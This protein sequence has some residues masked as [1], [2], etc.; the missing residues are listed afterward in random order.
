MRQTAVALRASFCLA[1]AFLCTAARPQPAGQSPASATRLS[2]SNRLL[3]N[4]AAVSGLHTIEVLLLVG[5][6]PSSGSVAHAAARVAALGGRVARTEPAIGYL[7]VEVPL[8]N[9]VTLVR[10]PGIQAF[11]I[12]S[13]SRGS[14]YR[15][16]PPMRNAELMRSFEVTALDVREP[17]TTDPHLPLLP[18][19]LSRQRGFTGDDVGVGRWLDE[20]PTFDGR[21]VTI[22]L[23]ENALPSFTDPT[24]RA[25]KTL[26]GRDVPKIA[27]ILNTADDTVADETRV[28]LDTSVRA[29]KAWTRVGSRTYVFPRPGAYRF[30]V[31]EVPAGTNL[32]HRFA[33]IE[34][35]KTNEVWMDTNGDASFHDEA[36]LADVNQRFEPRFLT[37]RHPSS[38]RVAFVTARGRRPHV[39][40]IYLS[41][42]SHQ[43][44]TLSVAAG[45]WTDESLASGVAPG[46]RV[47]LV[48]ISSPEPALARMFEGFM[49]AAQRPDVDVISA[50]QGTMLVP[51]TDADFSGVFFQRLEQVYRKPIFNSAGNRGPLVTSADASML[52]VGGVLS[53]ETWAALYGGRPLESL[54]VHPLSAAGPA[55]D[56]AIKPD[57]LAPVERISADLP[58]NSPLDVVPRN[59]PAHRLP[60]GYQIS[61]CTSASSPYAAGVAALLISAARQ[62]A[63]SYRGDRLA[64]ALRFSARLIPGGPA[65]WQGH[66]L[67]DIAAAWRALTHPIDRPHITASTRVVHPLAQYAARGEEGVGIVEFDGWTPGMSAIR[68]IV[69]TRHSGPEEPVTYPLAWAASDG[70]FSTPPSVTLP[71]RHAVQVPVRIE[72]RSEG[73]HSGLLELRDAATGAPLFRTQATVVA[74]PRVH[75]GTGTLRRTGTLTHMSHRSHYVHVQPGSTAIAFELEV[76]RGVVNPSIVPSHGLFPSYYMHAYPMNVFYVGKGKYVV[77]V[78]NPQPGTWTF[79]LKATSTTGNLLPTNPVRPDDSD[80]DYALTVRIYDAAS[81]LTEPGL[82]IAPGYLTTHTGQFLAS[83]LP[84][85]FEIDV[86]RDAAALSL[87]LRTTSVPPKAELYL[88]DC[89]TGECFSYNIG[90]PA[91]GAHTL[92]VRKPSAGRWI[93]AVNAAPF[94]AASPGAFV[95]DE[96]VTIRTPV[97]RSSAVAREPR[98]RWHAA[99]DGVA[100]PPPN[101]HR[102]PVIVVERVDLAAERAETEFPWSTAPNYVT[103]RDR[104]IALGTAVYRR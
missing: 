89:T 48:R 54:V 93:A 72:A 32:V 95:L 104:P 38:G 12:A 1:A 77:R 21:G 98:S 99:I 78:P 16:G 67:L 85:L 46:A 75:P 27:G 34:D 23:V 10:T 30:G 49:E 101:Q 76:T 52:S 91:A 51:D 26:D 33:V 103:L 15:D 22:A 56:G 58:W 71:L 40:H 18:P 59:R 83:G 42:G 7:R 37:L 39:L 84:N 6:T 73:V 29:A 74:A 20:H 43:S 41:R 35:E 45:S 63:I 9:V 94:V 24:V 44:M 55:I 86:P 57:F 70:S 11:Q 25:A 61:C 97:R 66:G 88:Y 2:F 60:A 28:R 19:R 31:Y 47:L 81:V 68:M 82:D 62:S 87:Q 4:R 53:P 3:L 64:D 36:P 92:V 100:P 80:V 50:S 65:H 8:A 69:F 96:L 90:F 5:P 79:T 17:K 102:T 14:W 13:L